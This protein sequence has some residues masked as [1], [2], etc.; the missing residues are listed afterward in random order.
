MTSKFANEELLTQGLVADILSVSKETVR[1][2][3]KNGELIPVDGQNL[4]RWLDLHKFPEVQGMLSSAW[5]TERKI[6]PV[7]KFRSIELFAGAGGLALGL[8]NAGF[9]SVAFNEFNHDSCDTLRKNRPHWNVIEGDVAQI[10]FTQFTDIDIV[11]G[12]FPCQAFSYAGNRFGFEDARGTLFF[13]FARVI[14]ETLP[15]VFLGENVRGLLTHDNGRTMDAIKSV[16]KDLGYTLVEPR[17]L[18]A[19]FYR[20]PQKRE[21][22]ALVGIRNDLANHLSDFKWPSPAQRV[23]TVRDA[24]KKGDLFRNDV[25]KSPGVSYTEWKADIIAKI[26]PGGYWRDLPIDLQK[27][28][29]KGSFHLGGGK[30]G[31]GRRLSWDE[32]SLTLTCAPAQNQTGRCHPSETRPLTVREYAR[33]QT[34]PDDWE[35]CGSVMSQYKQIGNAV[36]VNLAEALGRSLIAL[37]NKIEGTSPQIGKR[38]NVTLHGV[39]SHDGYVQPMLFEP[40]TL[41][42]VHKSP[43]TLLGTYRKSCRDWIVANN[44]YN[45]PVTDAE[46]DKC[47]YIRSVCRLIL[48]RKHDTLLSFSVTGY[49]IV[50]KKD[51]AA[52]GY[53]TGK[54]HPASQKYI[55]YKLSPLSTMPQFDESTAMPI[56]GK[57]VQ[58]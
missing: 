25:P 3:K 35:F 17:V 6:V 27:Q 26:P 5:D 47:Q 30:T 9:D 42:L 22:L 7:R 23:Y 44:L 28:L 21:R 4:Y 39:R 45:Y 58:L 51:L 24:L 43:V 50:S 33:I 49:S 34:F 8:E 55:L 29:L 31:I 54:N 52:L 12:G 46:L 14:R 53:N 48:M 15:R 18:K 2:W 32:P 56:V 10:D 41:Y 36:P 19:L 1:K 13:E 38:R 11:S 37:L 20:V 40:S 57:G 16:I